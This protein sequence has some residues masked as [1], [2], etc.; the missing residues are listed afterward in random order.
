MHKVNYV[1]DDTLST[2]DLKNDFIQKLKNDNNIEN[3]KTV[4]KAASEIQQNN[5]ESST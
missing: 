1:I 3:L 5:T 2:N 4:I